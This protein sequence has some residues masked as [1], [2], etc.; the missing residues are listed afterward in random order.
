[1]DNSLEIRSLVEDYMHIL[2]TK[3]KQA[4]NLKF[5]L[6]GSEPLTYKELDKVMN[7]DSELVVHRSL[8]K[9][10]EYFNELN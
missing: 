9:I 7:C 5:G 2:T 1:M 4:I 10:R 6:D 3:E 8:K